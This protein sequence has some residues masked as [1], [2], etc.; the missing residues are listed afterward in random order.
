AGR[1]HDPRLDLR[2][3]RWLSSSSPSCVRSL[4]SARA[5]TASHRD[6]LDVPDDQ[7][8]V[9]QVPL[10]LRVA[11]RLLVEGEILDDARDLQ[12]GAGSRH[13]RG[14]LLAEGNEDDVVPH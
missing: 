7:Y 3:T 14:R 9:T 4:R 1:G 5:D 12:G 2:R 13:E 10:E 6:H 11:H 8:T